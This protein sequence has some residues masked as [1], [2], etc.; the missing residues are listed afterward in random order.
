MD[1]KSAD[2]L[3]MYLPCD[4][5]RAKLG[6]RGRWPMILISLVILILIIIGATLFGV[7]M[8]R[9]RADKMTVM[10]FNSN[11]GEKIQQTVFVNGQENLAVIFIRN[12]NDSTVVLYDYQRRI[13]GFKQADSEKCYVIQM[14]KNTPS[15]SSI[16]R[17]TEY[18][19]THNALRDSEV[20]YNLIEQEAAG[21]AQLGVSVNL[22]CADSTIYWAQTA[23]PKDRKF[24][25]KFKVFGIPVKITVGK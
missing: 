16:I 20:S 19:Q 13:I 22:L 11:D 15:V 10:V 3:D 4:S 5:I 17:G 7:Y 14:D 18:F 2:K 1:Q 24:T 6:G 12:K 9:N 8:T 25:V 21:S 23:N